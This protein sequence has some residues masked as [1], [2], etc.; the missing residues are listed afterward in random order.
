LGRRYCTKLA[1]FDFAY[2][3]LGVTHESQALGDPAQHAKNTA[4]LKRA[5]AR[6]YVY[7]AAGRMDNA[8]PKLKNSSSWQN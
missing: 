6:E 7:A 1:W 5:K 2:L 4:R 8:V 3:N